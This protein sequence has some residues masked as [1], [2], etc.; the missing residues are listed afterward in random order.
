MN[1]VWIIAI[2]AGICWFTWQMM[3]ALA[4]GVWYLLCGLWWLAAWPVRKARA[5]RQSPV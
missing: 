3:R 1:P 2:V 5:R 4:V